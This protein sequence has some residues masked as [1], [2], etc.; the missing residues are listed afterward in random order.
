MSELISQ[1]QNSQLGNDLTPD[2]LQ[3]LAEVMSLETLTQGDNVVDA[4]HAGVLSILLE[5]SAQVLGAFEKEMNT[6][7]AGTILGEVSFLDGGA[8]S[9]KVVCTGPAKVG[10]LNHAAVDRLANESPDV[11]VVLYRNISLSLCAKLRT[12]T[13]LIDTLGIFTV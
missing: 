7:P 1:L 3:K 9:A 12:A 11:A 13:R 10:R 4:A 5:G 6:V 2:Q 8:P